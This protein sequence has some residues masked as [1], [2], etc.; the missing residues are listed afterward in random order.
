MSP[1]GRWNVHTIPPRGAIRMKP[2]KFA[3][4]RALRHLV[5]TSS[6]VLLVA[7][8]APTVSWAG[9]GDGLGG[10]RYK[11]D[12]QGG[13][14]INSEP[15]GTAPGASP[16]ALEDDSTKLSGDPSNAAVDRQY[17]VLLHWM[18]TVRLILQLDR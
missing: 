10:L 2:N 14:G 4:K 3:A 12:D 11:V 17:V 1:V 6:L 7:L 15:S 8:I 5:L 18:R 9:K 16:A 13:G